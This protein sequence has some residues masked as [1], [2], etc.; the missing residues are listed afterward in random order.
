MRSPLLPP[1]ILI[2][3]TNPHKAEEIAAILRLDGV[4]LT[5]LP[6]AFPQGFHEADETGDSFEANALVKAR[7]YARLSGLPTLAEDSGLVVDAL[8]GAPG[9]H[10]SRWMGEGTPYDEKNAR[11]L[12]LLKDVPDE[13]RTARFVCHA[14]VSSPDGLT[15]TGAQGVHE[16]RI[17]HQISGEGGFGYDPVFESLE[18]G[19]TF[20]ELSTEVKNRVSHR[21][22]ALRLVA[23][24]LLL[25]DAV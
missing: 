20:G 8:G 19:Q 25:R 5:T 11:L 7:F 10:S 24:S 2:A 21:A 16:G 23:A 1:R 14:V 22:R 12:E 17:A 18:L 13:R 15:V 6:Q 9:V 4:E 3:T